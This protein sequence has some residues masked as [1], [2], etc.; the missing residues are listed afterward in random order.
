MATCSVGW[1]SWRM[2]I[3]STLSGQHITAFLMDGAWLK[4]RN[5]Q[6]SCLGMRL[7]Q[8]RCLFL[9]SFPTWSS[10]TKNRQRHSGSGSLKVPVGLN[11]LLCTLRS[12][13][14]IQET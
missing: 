13:S 2:G 7:L 12:M 1:R 9:N 11:I 4:Y 6:H 10:W 14:S 3:L 8:S 5:L